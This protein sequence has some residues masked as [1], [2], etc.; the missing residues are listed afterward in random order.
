MPAI[1]ERIENDMIVQER[2]LW[3]ALTSAS[4]TDEL[5]RLCDE[6]AVLLF[7]KKDITT[8]ETL[9]ETFTK[10]F[11]KFDEYDL[12]DVRND[13]EPWTGYMMPLSVPDPSSR[14]RKVL[15][16]GAGIAGL[17]VAL[18][19]AKEL[20]PHEPGLQITLYERHDV[21]STS[22]GALNL[23]P[24]AQRHLEGLGVLQELFRQGPDGGADVDAIELF[25]S[26]SGR[27]LGKA[28]FTDG[29]GNGVKG[30]KGLR[31]MRI[32]LSLALLAVLE[33]KPNIKIVYGKK[34]KG[35]SESND[36][37]ILHFEDNTS[38]AGD[39]VLG[40]DGVHSALRTHYVEP[41]RPSEYT[42]LAFIQTTIDT[43]PPPPAS[44]RT[45][46]SRP[47][48]STSAS[49]STHNSTKSGRTTRS[50][51]TNSLNS[52]HTLSSA[53]Q[54]QT[55][56]T[57]HAPPFITSGL[58]LSRHGDLLG[59]YCDRN[60]ATLFLAAI[61]QIKETLLPG[62]R[63]DGH[64]VTDPRHRTAIHTALQN[65]IHSRFAGSGIPWVRDVANLK[66][67]WMLYPVYQVRPGGRW[68][69][70]RVIL[71]GDAAHAM[72]PRDESAA[73]ALDDSIMFS[74]TFAHHR[75]EPLSTIFA[76]YEALRRGPVEEAFS[77]AGRMWE[78]HRDM[79]FLE[80]RWKEWTM[81][82]FLWKN[83]AARNAAWRFDAYES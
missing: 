78:T 43:P 79:G 25:S 38:A 60:H 39:L 35:V 36:Q 23:S 80:G 56:P 44:N 51:S 5:R 13:S 53:G 77:A 71:L 17:A 32:V 75:D 52:S 64:H 20:G 16:V 69:K 14:Q 46:F 66:T 19:L 29:H 58:V 68:W 47:S 59:S 28:E 4:P 12:Q 24:V 15:I 30:Y 55:T 83:R 45:S 54:V 6:R 26:R 62:Y 50:V 34:V 82:Y 2:T 48:S 9:E 3:S 31:V 40:C 21:L 27:S 73:Y 22:G 42:G 7:P 63:M 11:H 81:P 8:V 72:P 57:M 70:G 37:T 41:G 18:S 49:G 65:E 67:N 33:R 76:K 74:R 61:V 10:G 1:Y